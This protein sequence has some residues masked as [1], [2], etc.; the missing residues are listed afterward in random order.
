MEIFSWLY[1][2]L[3]TSLKGPLCRLTKNIT[4]IA[5]LYDVMSLNLHIHL[6]LH[7]GH[8]HHRIPWRLKENTKYTQ[9]AYNKRT[10]HENE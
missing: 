3:M 2:F 4:A 10:V 5:V 8:I 9:K 7:W 1:N 6:H